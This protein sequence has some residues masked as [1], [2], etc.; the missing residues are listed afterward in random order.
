MIYLP[1]QLALCLRFNTL[2]VLGKSRI[3]YT[4][5]VWNVFGKNVL[6]ERWST[7][8]Y[9]V[10]FRVTSPV[11]FGALSHTLFDQGCFNWKTRFLRSDPHG[12]RYNGVTQKN[13]FSYH[14]RGR[15]TLPKVYERGN[16]RSPVKKPSAKWP[17]SDNIKISCRFLGA[18]Q[19]TSTR[20]AIDGWLRTPAV[21]TGLI[22]PVEIPGR[23]H[24]R[25]HAKGVLWLTSYGQGGRDTERSRVGDGYGH[26]LSLMYP[27]AHK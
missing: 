9:A 14:R 27:A 23:T 2:T 21:V 8:W 12:P 3:R 4:L 5:A 13:I 26:L 18:G 16:G 1:K 24:V 11:F 19:A 22:L 10:S 6:A 15:L 17:P 7:K 20:A 25:G